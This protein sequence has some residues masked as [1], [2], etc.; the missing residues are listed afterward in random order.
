M[1][2]WQRMVI[3]AGVGL[4]AACG[5][6]GAGGGGGGG[7]GT[8]DVVQACP[9]MTGPG[10][11][12][13]TYSGCTNCLLQD[14]ELAIDGVLETYATITIPALVS[15]TIALRA[16]A[17][18]GTEYPALRGAGAVL[19]SG[20][21]SGGSTFF[22]T[23]YELRTY[24]AGALVGSEGGTDVNVVGGNGP[25]EPAVHEFSSVSPYDAVEV[26][27][28]QASGTSE[29]IVRIHEFCAGDQ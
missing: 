29:T 17:P 28:T 23:G 27:F 16:T 13:G 6:G 25:S 15:G 11:T 4:A 21:A 24:Y 20:G 1:R 12:H 19:S 10:F 3:G 14:P 8:P 9:Y 22:D 2:N 18:T 26:A 5:G 7:S